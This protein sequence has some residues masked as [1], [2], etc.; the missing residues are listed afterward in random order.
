MYSFELL[1]QKVHLRATVQAK[2]LPD[3][4]AVSL[5]TFNDLILKLKPRKVFHDLMKLLEH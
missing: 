1:N 4:V 5:L 2:N 3:K